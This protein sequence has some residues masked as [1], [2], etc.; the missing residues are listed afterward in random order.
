MGLAQPYT[1]VFPR[2]EDLENTSES[3]T[4]RGHGLLTLQTVGGG[5]GGVVE[6][7]ASLV[8]QLELLYRGL[9]QC[10]CS[11]ISLGEL[12]PRMSKSCPMPSTDPLEWSSDV[13]I[14]WSFQT[15]V[16]LSICL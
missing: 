16:R 2:A 14:F 9:H 1:V 10:S 12:K 6:G 5:G 8:P 13:R 7:Q 11:Q 3:S 15:T 4:H